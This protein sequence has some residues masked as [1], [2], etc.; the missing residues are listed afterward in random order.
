MSATG[1]RVHDVILRGGRTLRLRPPSEADAAA[2]RRFLTDLSPASMRMRFHGTRRV[3]DAMVAAFLDPD[4]IDEGILLA[5]AVGEDESDR[6]IGTAGFTRLRDPRAAEV[7]FVVAEDRQSDWIATRLL[8]RLADEA[9]RAGIERFIAEVLPENRPMLRVFEDSGFEVSRTDEGGEIRVEFPIRSDERYR[10][11]VDLRDHRAVGPSLRPVLDPAAVAVVGA[12]ARDGS[13]GGAIFRNIV[14]AGYTG[15][16][17]PVNRSGEP[18]AGHPAHASVAD[19]PAPVDLAVVAVPSAAVQGAVAEALSAGAKAVCVISAGFAETGPGGARAEAELL[20]LVRSHG[21]RM[22]GP[23]CLGIFAAARAMNATFSRRQF[24]PGNVAISSQS[25]AVGLAV[26]DE[27][28]Q[29]G[30]GLSA[31]VS[32]GNK[33]DVSSNDLLEYWEDDAGTDAIALYLESFGNPRRFARIANRVARRKPILA[34][35]SGS[36]TMGERAAMSHTAALAGSDQAAEALFRQAGVLRAHTLQELCD[37]LHLV[38]TQ[39]LPNGRR[40]AILSNAGGL[41]ILCA[42]ACAEL[43]FELAPLSEHTRQHLAGILPDEATVANPV[44]MI[45]SATSETFASV[46]PLLVADTDVDALVVLAAPTSLAMPEDV[47]RA[48]GEACEREGTTKPVLAVTPGTTPQASSVPCYRYPEAAAGALARA[49]ERAEWLRRPHGRVHEPVVDREAAQAVVDAALE[50][51][52]DAWLAADPARRL[53][54]AYGVPCVTQRTVTNR[55]EA[56]EAAHALRYPLAVKM[57]EAGV[58]KIDRGGVILGVGDVPALDAALDRIGYPA[59]LQPMVSGGIELLAGVVQDPVFGPVV[60]F[61][62]GGTM[63]EL[64]GGT[65][66]ATLP[67]TDFD[68]TELVTSGKAGELVTGFRGRPAADVGALVDLVVRLAALAEDFPQV[69]EL[70]LNPVI[71]LADD[72]VAVDARVRIAHAAPQG[73]L[74]SW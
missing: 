42:D 45:A 46:V 52:P 57:G 32:I 25:G 24:E 22:V 33:A 20:A 3:D 68:A 71:A 13:I 53:L 11:A 43:G 35:K 66:F 59:V 60:A 58:H 16:V 63:A 61:G 65:A 72:C 64:I 38:A 14:D 70:D 40:V 15:S 62:P 19:L 23:N 1:Q 31:F 5:T 37:V 34:L 4:W 2:M 6:V 41:A 50:A 47:V 27:A 18:V 28:S 17:F 29:R 30:L 74:K 26:I 21:A 7:S 12:S 51:S 67:L 56:L 73:R 10:E 9:G 49:V 48:I 54:T 55:P 8:E 69:A 44:D 39:P 36:T